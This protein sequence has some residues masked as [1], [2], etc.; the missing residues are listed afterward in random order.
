MPLPPR[1]RS[2]SLATAHSLLFALPVAVAL[3]LGLASPPSAE[4]AVFTVNDK[5]DF[6]DLLPGDGLCDTGN[7]RVNAPPLFVVPE[8]TLRAALEEANALPGA[9]E[10]QFGSLIPLIAT[11]A[12]FTPFSPYPPVVDEVLINGYSHP[13][14][15]SASI[16][17]VPTPIVQII[18]NSVP[19]E[20]SGLQF[21][22]GSDGST[23]F[24]VAV[25]QFPGSGIR[26]GANS[27]TGPADITIGGSHIGASR[28][29]FMFGNDDYGILIQSGASN[30]TIGM[31]CGNVLGC[32]GRGNLISA[33]ML[34]GISIRGSNNRIAGNLIGTDSTGGL[35]FV[36]FGGNTGNGGSGVSI[37]AGTN[38]EIGSL[39]A[40]NLGGL[41][42]PTPVAAG[43]LISANGSSGI[44]IGPEVL[45]TVIKA[46]QIGTNLAGSGLLAND[47]HGVFLYGEAVIGDTGLGGNLIAGVTNTVPGLIDQNAGIFSLGGLDGFLTPYPVSVIG[48]RIG[49]NA[50]AD[51]TLGDLD[52]GVFLPFSFTRATVDDNIIGGSGVGILAT[53]ADVRRNYLGTNEAGD[54][55]GNLAR[56][57]AGSNVVLGGDLTDSNSVAASKGNIIAFSGEVGVGIGSHSGGVTAR[58]NRF[59]ANNGI[60]FDLG[61]EPIDPFDPSTSQPPDG[62]TANDV[63]DLDLGP[64][65][66]QNFPEFNPAQTTYDAVANEVT[67]RLRVDSLPTSSAY[68]LLVDIYARNPLEDA[69]DPVGQLIGSVVIN[70]PDASVFVTETFTPL[71][72]AFN[73]DPNSGAIYAELY[74]VT[75]DSDGLSSEFSRE[76]VPVPEPS[77][78]YSVL[79][80]AALLG[81]R[82]RAVCSRCA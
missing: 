72:G 14:Y 81:F 3:S 60:P 31:A 26:I 5:T 30:N 65:R 20:T 68:P 74:A 23:V 11:F 82:K 18:G 37:L 15:D 7:F 48:N 27:V 28:G 62:P 79:A 80:G 52:L 22:P 69:S 57:F 16:N 38:N 10:I 9:D 25:H 44:T 34:S 2:T 41:G 13:D 33:N 42:G 77:F 67:V 71:P 19:A 78:A 53:D 39:G 75:T 35:D 50:G 46:N 43:N 64:N 4:A 73:P 51:A 24:G 6:A 21:A 66:L 12:E 59:R 63:G 32:L 1:S 54:D 58:G 40:V 61:P 70:E 29:G 45:G 56:G 76:L 47:M 17:P 49:V 36:P 55:L 8:C